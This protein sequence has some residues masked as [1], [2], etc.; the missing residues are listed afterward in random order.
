MLIL[1]MLSSCHKPASLN[2]LPNVQGQILWGVTLAQ[3]PAYD[4]DQQDS[5]WSMLYQGEFYHE[6]PTESLLTMQILLL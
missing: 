6:Q 3:P 4:I 1:F 5:V 2:L